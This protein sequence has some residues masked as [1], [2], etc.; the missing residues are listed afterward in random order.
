MNFSA[1]LINKVVLYSNTMSCLISLSQGICIF[2]NH[3][4]VSGLLRPVSGLLGPDS[5]L[6]GPA[7]GP[8]GPVSG[9]LGTWR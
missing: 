9:P 4:P 7:S 5:G 2:Y 3:N 1:L 8:L 6:L